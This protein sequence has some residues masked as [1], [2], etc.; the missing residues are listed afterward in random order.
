MYQHPNLKRGNFVR[1]LRSLV[2]SEVVAR[3][4]HSADSSLIGSA[5]NDDADYADVVASAAFNVNVSGLSLSLPFRFI[6]SFMLGTAVATDNL[7]IHWYQ[8]FDS[9]EVVE[10][11]TMGYELNE[12]V[13]WPDIE[14]RLRHLVDSDPAHDAQRAAHILDRYQKLWSPEALARYVM[15]SCE[16]AIA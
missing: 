8:P 14:N 7:S 9:E 2:S 12:D 6:D 5:L 4:V 11:G 13:N 16:E 1:Y 10:L 15:Q 3:L